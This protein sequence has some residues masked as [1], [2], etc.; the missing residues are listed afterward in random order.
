MCSTRSISPWVWQRKP[1]ALSS[2]CLFPM[3]PASYRSKKRKKTSQ[4][5]QKPLSNQAQRFCF[6]VEC[7]SEMFQPAGDI[8]TLVK[9]L[10]IFI[11]SLFPRKIHQLYQGLHDSRLPDQCY[12]SQLFL[13]IFGIALQSSPQPSL[14]LPNILNDT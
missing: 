9:C 8:A 3:C 2:A 1:R 12:K 13:L 7:G 11:L 5:K 6:S 4:S 10:V 14:R